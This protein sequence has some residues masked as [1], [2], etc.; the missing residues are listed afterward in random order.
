MFCEDFSSSLSKGYTYNL[1]T[2]QR[3]FSYFVSCLFIWL[4]VTFAEQKFLI[5]STFFFSFINGAFAFGVVFMKNII[6]KPT[7]I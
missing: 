4:E 7:V 5:L 2:M 1:D 6:V 3:F